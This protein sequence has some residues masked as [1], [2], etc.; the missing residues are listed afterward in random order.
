VVAFDYFGELSL[1][2]GLFTVHGLEI[3]SGRIHTF[4]P[5]PAE[6]AAP[7]RPAGAGRRRPGWRLDAMPSRK[8]VDIFRVV[9]RPAAAPDAAA[10]EREL[11]ELLG[12]AGEGRGEEARE[13]LNR[14]LAESFSDARGEAGE[15]AMAEALAPLE[16][17]FDDDASEG[18]TV[19]DVR[20]RDTPG[21][22]Y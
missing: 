12:V 15:A 9:P 11:R 10:R 4:A 18:W 16:I 14:R 17:T 1:I 6:T 2:C 8:I 3:E 19:M 21:F 7:P 22:L 20:G 13:A 5:P